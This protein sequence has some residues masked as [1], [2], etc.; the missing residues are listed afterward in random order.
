MW[1]FFLQ[2]WAERVEKW[3]LTKFQLGGWPPSAPRQAHELRDFLRPAAPCAI[4]MMH[5]QATRHMHCATP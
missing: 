5:G 2:K 1:F 4:C 3:C